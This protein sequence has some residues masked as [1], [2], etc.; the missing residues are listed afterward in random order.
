MDA[1]WSSTTLR[2]LANTDELVAVRAHAELMDAQ[3]PF[4]MF[5]DPEEPWRNYLAR[6][7]GYR[8][9]K[10][11]LD[12]MVPATFLVAVHNDEIVGRVH[13]RHELNDQLRYWGGHIGYVVRP[14]FRRRGYA[15]EIL[16][17]ALQYAKRLGVGDRALLT[18]DDS[19]QGSIAVIERCGGELE[20]S[21]PATV[22][23]PARRYYWIPLGLE[24]A[25]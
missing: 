22:D 3:H 1:D 7:E 18:C 10:H 25:I 23:H 4:L 16:A 24:V 11:L 6:L 20:R 19:N 13:I 15:T 9:G 12:R 17:M 14:R 21:T 8:H 5:F 2:H